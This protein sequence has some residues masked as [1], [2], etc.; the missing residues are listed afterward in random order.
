MRLFFLIAC[1]YSLSVASFAQEEKPDYYKTTFPTEYPT[2][3]NYAGI[4]RKCDTIVEIYINEVTS[5]RSA[6]YISWRNSLYTGGWLYIDKNICL[7]D[8]TTSE[9]H[10]LSTTENGAIA[11][12]M[13]P[14]DLGKSCNLSAIPVPFPC[15][16]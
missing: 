2:L 14:F 6:I 16:L 1:L 9:K 5:K 8:M 15:Q 12:N 4:V 13:P 11:P 3:F 10:A 7:F